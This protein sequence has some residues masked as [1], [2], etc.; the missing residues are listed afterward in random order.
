[1]HHPPVCMYSGAQSLTSWI[2]LIL[3]LP[4]GKIYK[5]GGDLFEITRDASLVFVII[6]ENPSKSFKKV[7]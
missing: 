2:N 7:L 4:G 3:M 6:L 5:A 1:M